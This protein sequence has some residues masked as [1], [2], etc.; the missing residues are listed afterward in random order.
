MA[1]QQSHFRQVNLKC[2]NDQ[3]DEADELR[4]QKQHG[5]NLNNANDEAIVTNNTDDAL[6]VAKH[7]NLEKASIHNVLL[8]LGSLIEESMARDV[9]STELAISS[10]RQLVIGGN[11]P[12]DDVPS[13]QQARDAMKTAILCVFSFRKAFGFYKFYCG[14]SNK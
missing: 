11:G 10:V 9:I 3:F 6:S 1:E 8:I 4:S 2:T 5:I 7:T 14:N 12:P 13:C